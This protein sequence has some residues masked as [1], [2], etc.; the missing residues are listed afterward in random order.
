MAK[1]KAGPKEAWH[2]KFRYR[3]EKT[4]KYWEVSLV[5]NT[6]T[7]TW[8]KVGSMGQQRTRSFSSRQVAETY[9]KSKIREKTG[10]GYVETEHA[11]L[12]KISP[13]AIATAMKLRFVGTDGGPLIVLPHELLPKWNGVFNAAGEY[14]Y[15]DAPCDF[16]APS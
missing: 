11:R 6:V 15:E 8:G 12:D 3:D 5:S 7:L 9:I 16:V 4:S 10:K 2:R 1:S 13:K 14:I